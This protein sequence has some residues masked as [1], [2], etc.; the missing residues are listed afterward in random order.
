VNVSNETAQLPAMHCGAVF[1]RSPRKRN[2]PPAEIA[3]LMYKRINDRDMMA[4][5]KKH[6]VS[7]DW[8]LYGDLR[9][10]QR[11][12]QDAKAT[13]QKTPEAL[14]K[15]VVALFSALSPQ[16][17]SFA[18]GRIREMLARSDQ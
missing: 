9:G 18:L 3:K 12:T 6:K 11:M 7:F 2:L 1:G 14:R 16:M 17:Q 13:P 5:C 4:F 8:L 10:L 15:E